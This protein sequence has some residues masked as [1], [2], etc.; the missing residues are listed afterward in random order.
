MSYLIIMIQFI[1]FLDVEPERSVRPVLTIMKNENT[2][3]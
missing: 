3:I 1:N 2:N